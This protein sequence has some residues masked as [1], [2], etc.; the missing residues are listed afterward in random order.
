MSQSAKDTH[1]MMPTEDPDYLKAFHLIIP[2]ENLMISPLT[3]PR[4]H[5]Y[6]ISQSLSRFSPSPYVLLK[7]DRLGQREQRRAL[8]RAAG[9]ARLRRV[10]CWPAP[11]NVHVLVTLRMLR[12]GWGGMLSFMYMLCWWCY[13]EVA[14]RN[15][16]RPPWCRSQGPKQKHWKSKN[17]PHVE[18]PKVILYCTGHCQ[19]QRQ[20]LK[21]EAACINVLNVLLHVP[22]KK[23]T[24]LCKVGISGPWKWSTVLYKAW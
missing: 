4:S 10:F 13:V 11:L 8:R 5:V 1:A 22:Q 23:P 12:V 21:S 3:S 16:I 7:R 2:S 15:A 18:R 14:K 9:R 24:D 6:P 17:S 19:R 20:S